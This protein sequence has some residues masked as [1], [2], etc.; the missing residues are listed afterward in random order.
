MLP[1]IQNYSVYPSVVLADTPTEMTIVPNERAFLLFEGEEY[2]IT[3]ISVNSDE[4]FYYKP[5]SHKH[6][7]AVASGGVLR[8]TYTF[9]GEG[10]HLIRLE[11]S[12]K[13]LHTMC[14]Y[15]LYSDLH[16]LTPL[17]GDLHSHSYRSDGKG[18]PVALAGHFREQGYDFF[19]LTDH[20]RFYPGGEIDEAYDGVKLAFTRVKGEEVHTPESV[21]HIV[22]V[23]GNHSVAELYVNHREEYEA[24]LAQYLTKVPEHIPEKYRARYAAAMWSTD[25]IHEAGGIA[26]F[27]HPFWRPSASSVYNVCDELALLLLKSGMFDAYEVVGAM[28]QPDSNRSVA[29][30]ADLRAE[31]FNIPVVASS[32]VHFVENSPT[33]PHSFTICFA[34]DRDGE[35]IINA[36]KAH[37]SV[38]VEA[39]GEEYKRQYRCY[40]SMRLVSYAQFLL[41]NYFSN[42]TRICQ[43]EGVAMRSYAMGLCDKN[44]VELQANQSRLFSER[45]FGRIEAPIPTQEILDFED[46]WRQTQL[47]GPKTKG[48]LIDSDTITRQI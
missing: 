34:E 39:V 24:S 1:I 7:T 30:W 16:A 26:I 46:K 25:R 23:G 44:T 4:T 36:V 15:S 33:F 41:K 29:M 8:F 47:N 35:S 38:A 31:G 11:H 2:S 14:I 27:P 13:N 32:D 42:L 21:V 43:G 3:V 17:R 6:L 37:R 19:A 20:N 5:K 12:G 28:S 48:S 45:F 9:S 22:H 18:D 10:E 40:G